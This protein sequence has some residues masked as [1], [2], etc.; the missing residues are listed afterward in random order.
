MDDE[1]AGEFPIQR[2]RDMKN[3]LYYFL[4]AM[5]IGMVILILSINGVFSGQV[6]DTGNL[7]INV[8][9]LVIIGILFMISSVSFIRLNKCTDALV[10]LTDSMYKA[11]DDGNHN[12]WEEYSTKKQPFGHEVLDDAFLRYQKKMRTFQTKRGLVGTCDI[13]DYI[14]EGLLNKV[15]MSYFNSAISGTM[16]GLGILGTFIGLSIGLGSF[17]GDDIYTISENIGP[18]LEGM[19]VAF[20]TSVYGI[21][22]SLIF[23]FVYRCIMSDAYD[24]LEEFM[25]CY[26]E[27]VEPSVATADENSKAML[28]YQANIANSMKQMTELLQGNALEQTKGV[29]IIVQQFLQ[30]MEHSMGTNFAKMGDTLSKACDAQQIYA[31][32]YKSMEE[33]TRTL[34]GTSLTLQQTLETT[35]ANQEA[36]AK[37]L[38]AQREKIDATCDT[39][40]EEISSQLYTFGVMKDV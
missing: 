2:R 16:T 38:V 11:Y 24:K 40:T 34:L 35:M 27:C 29:E 1:E 32:N 33:T 36:L 9:F 4:F 14:H 25:D 3:K 21:F 28:I 17:N 7:I 39:I 30:Q 22:F 20:H 18:L 37:E 13:E 8:S 12:L 6:A 19:K 15:S 5:Y 23:T 31:E 10:A 26:R